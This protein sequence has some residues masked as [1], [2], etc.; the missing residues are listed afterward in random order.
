MRI[1]L[2]LMLK[3]IYIR[4]SLVALFAIL[5]ALGFAAGNL[6]AQNNSSSESYIVDSEEEPY[7][8]PSDYKQWKDSYKPVPI[9]DAAFS[10]DKKGC[11]HKM[12]FSSILINKFKR[13]EGVEDLT[14]SRILG[15]Y[16]DVQF[17]DIKEK[18][19]LEAQKQIMQDYRECIKNSEKEED[20]GEEYDQNMRYGA[21]DKLN[22]IFMGTIEG[23]KKRNSIDTVIDRYQKD[24]PDLSETAFAGIP[25]AS[26]MFI[27]EIY[28]KASQMDAQGASEGDK[29]D[30]LYEYAS[31]MIIAC[32]L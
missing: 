24:F 14:K 22:T 23:I 4:R 31:K 28:E 1:I 25:D 9:E 10:K 6:W 13:G 30:S 20:P 15:E 21:C 5:C 12:A 18:G 29:Y 3:K 2:R 11:A 17:D 26:L 16:L 32:T 27:G 19:T 7:Y 8:D